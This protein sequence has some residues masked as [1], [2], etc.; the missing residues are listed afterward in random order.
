MFDTKVITA[1]NSPKAAENAVMAPASTPG[2]TRGRCTHASRRVCP[3]NR[4]RV[5]THASRIATGRLRATLRAATLRL[6]CRASP[7]LGLSHI[8]TGNSRCRA[9]CGGQ[10]TVRATQLKDPMNGSLSRRGAS[11]RCG[12][13]RTYWRVARQLGDAGFSIL[14]RRPALLARIL[15]RPP[16][17]QYF[18]PDLVA[19]AVR[20]DFAVSADSNRSK[21]PQD[22]AAGRFALGGVFNAPD[23][24][25]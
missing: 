11:G 14:F 4:R 25:G 8:T 13:V 7:S 5:S 20:A 1:P 21:V 16:R 19:L 9:S 17:H 22:L 15:G 10:Y 6:K 12:G 3:R 18:P 23:G 2:S 24:E